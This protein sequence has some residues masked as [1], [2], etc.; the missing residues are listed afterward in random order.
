MTQRCERMV[1]DGALDSAALLPWVERHARKLGLEQTV[2]QADATRLI[3]ELTG[4]EEL[5]DAMEIGCLLGP[6]DVWV[7]AIE[8]SVK[9]G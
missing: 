7:D 5:I 6:I 9:H 2:R 8:R 1:I 4:P 3:L